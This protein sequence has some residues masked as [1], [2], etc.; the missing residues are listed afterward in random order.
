MSLAEHLERAA[1]LHPERGFHVVSHGTQVVSSLSYGELDRQARAAASGLEPGVPVVLAY[2][3]GS[4]EFLVAFWACVYADAPAVPAPAPHPQRLQRTLPRL[5]QLVSDSQ[6]QQVLT[7]EALQPL[8]AGSQRLR[9][10]P[11]RFRPGQGLALLQYTSGSTRQ[12]R[13]VCVRHANLLH[14]LAMLAEFHG[15]RQPQRMLCWLPLYHDMGLIRAMLSTVQAA[16]EGYLMDPWEFIQHPGRWLQGLQHFG[17]NLTGAPNFGYER[18]V[19]KAPGQRFD[20]SRLEVAFCTAEPIRA[21]TLR[22][23]EQLLQLPPQVLK[24]SYGLAENTVMV[25]GQARPCWR[26]APGPQG[27]EWVSCGIAW[28]QQRLAIVDDQGKPQAPGQLGE[29][30]VQGDSVA[31]GY[32]QRPQESQQV[33]AARLESDPTPWLRT[34]DQGYLTAEGELCLTGRLKDLLIVR[35]QNYY[36][37]ELEAAVE[38][39][40]PGLRPGCSAALQNDDQVVVLVELSAPVPSRELVRRVQAA[41]GEEFGLSLGQLVALARGELSKTASGKVQRSL[42]RQ[43]WF[44]G[45]LETLWCWSRPGFQQGEF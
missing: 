21:R 40:H 18:V 4:L 10:G 27:R 33:F 5:Q 25:T 9:L 32:W 45:Q 8:I 42:M 34:G 35:G 7:S 11:P 24:T 17:C 30:W 12:P 15:L 28:G 31:A 29:V 20:L 44:N 13:G 37:H 1:R 26:N 36:P 3:S 14:N 2:P 16:G 39:C 41:L 22:A 6:A 19:R 23:F 38:E 43:R